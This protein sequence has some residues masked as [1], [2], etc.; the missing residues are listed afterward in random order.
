M[1]ETFTINDNDGKPHEYVLALHPALRGLAISAQLMS[2]GVEP[3]ATLADAAISG[4]KLSALLLDAL[5]TPEP[6]DKPMALSEQA[7]ALIED[8]DLV[9]LLSDLDLPRVAVAVRSAISG[10]NLA[11]LAPEILSECQR[12]GITLK[13]AAID[14]AYA[15]NYVE[16]LTACWRVIQ[17]NRF[18]SLAGI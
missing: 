11:A 3:L 1:A 8:V 17:V 4:E 16:L 13:P 15:G 7:E 6:G 14:L 2:I 12:D 9:A 10:V 18:L 5:G